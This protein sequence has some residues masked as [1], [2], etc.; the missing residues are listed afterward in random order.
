[1]P[2]KETGPVHERMQFIEAYL[3]GFYTITELAARYGISR[4]IAHKW[5]SRHDRN[6]AAGLQDRSRAPINIPH[7]TTDDIVAE[8]VSFRRRF[9]H[10]G[11]R[12]IAVRLAELHPEIEWP[13]PST[14]G[15]I[16]QRADLVS[17]RRRR[18]PP[19]HP[20]RARAVATAPNDLMTVDY[21][22]EFLLGNH[23]YCYPLTIVDHV[24]RF[25]LACIAFA[26]TQYEHTRPAFERVFREFG[27]PLAILSDNGSPFGSPGLARLSRLSLWWIRLGISVE[28]IVPGHPEQNG[29]HERMHR[30][31]KAETTRPPES[32]FERQQQRFDQFRQHFNNE[33]PHEALGQK[34]PASLY[35]PS[36]RPYPQRLPPL[37]YPGHLLTRKVDHSG[38]IRWKNDARLFLSHTLHGET[39]GLEEID[40]GVWSLYYGTVLLARFDEREKRFYG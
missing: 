12:K 26:S 2:W 5:L 4:R 13:A 31:L 8:V 24:S 1:M 11:P 29:A 40:D 9:P 32:T 30:T 37:E 25:L 22:G 38:L 17:P 20:L 27:L 23:Q 39:V 18:N 33:R 14:I 10:M 19:A 16:L 36:P 3:T 7:R 15:D 35:V 28:R 21:K 6:G 34:R